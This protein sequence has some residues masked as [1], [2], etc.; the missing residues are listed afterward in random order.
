VRRN[1][2]PQVA[3]K[4]LERYFELCELSILVDFLLLPKDFAASLQKR[5]LQTALAGG[6]SGEG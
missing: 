1:R 4:K 6:K 5:R 3:Q 2:R